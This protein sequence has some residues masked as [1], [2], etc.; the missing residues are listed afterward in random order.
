MTRTQRPRTRL[1]RRVTRSIL[2]FVAALTAVW[3]VAPALIVLPLSVTDQRSLRFPPRG[4]SLEWFRSFIDDPAWRDAAV[5]SVKVGVLTAVIATAV[6]AAAALGL[7]QC[8]PR[9]RTALGA[10]FLAPMIVPA[11]VVAIGVYA[12][13]LRAGLVATLPGFV[14]AHT[15]VAFPFSFTYIFAGLQQF[16][17][18]LELAAHSLGANRISTFVHVTFPMMLPSMLASLLFSFVVSFDETVLSIFLADPY[19]TTLPVK[20][21]NGIKQDIDPTVAATAALMLVVSTSLIALGL[22]VTYRNSRRRGA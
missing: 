9:F 17:R 6:A 21:F 3:L 22:F 5:N 12:V 16:D 11:I 7:A 15:M 8:G 2:G 18:R 14:L 13:F 20:M 1:G 19:T 10:L 4:T